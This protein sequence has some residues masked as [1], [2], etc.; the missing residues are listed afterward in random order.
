M[1]NKKKLIYIFILVLLTS[2]S[3]DNKTGI[4]NAG[5]KERERLS[6][7]EEEQ[8]QIISSTKV[9][10]SENTFSKE[11]SF[12]NV[13]N[14]SKPKQ[15]SSWEMSGLNYQNFL[16][17]IFLPNIDNI[18]LKKKIG[19]NKFS[20]T[21]IVSAPLVTESSII[22]SD[23]R[24][25]IFNISHTGKI[26]WKKNI[27]KKIHKKIYKNLV[28]SIYENNLYIADN[29]GFIYALDLNDGKLIWIKNHGIPLKSNIKIF[30]NKIFLINQDNRILCLN[31]KNGNKIWDIRSIASF[32]KSQSFL[33]LA[34]TKEGNVVL[35]NSAGDLIKVNGDTGNIFWALNAS[36]SML[37]HD[38]DFFRSSDIVLGNK[39]IFFSTGSSIFSYNLKN[40]FINWE[41]DVSTHGT[42][43]IDRNNIFLVTSNGYFVVLD[44]KTGKIISSNNILKKLKKRKQETKIAGFIMGSGKIYS[45][46]LN[47]YLIINSAISGNV[48]RVIKVGD[49]VT[50]PPIIN[51]KKLYILT[52]NSKIIGFN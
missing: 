37:A 31:A 3:F 9:Y 12:N 32:I 18:F 15:N 16:G 44:K 49:P 35:I 10:S 19:K 29:I 26:K 1:I 4:W 23:N 42:P 51:D 28:F 22:L 48:E 17:N 43:I 33:S 6:K 5:K 14:L 13:I 41:Q 34:V 38:T 11:I 25:I 46:T 20:I 2:C 7:L 52:K 36:S 21:K 50:S 24:G 8:R 45:V 39:S 47:G 40:G 27:Y 30:K